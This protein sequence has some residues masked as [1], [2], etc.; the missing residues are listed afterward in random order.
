MPSV[1]ALVVAAGRGERLSSERPKQ[2]LPLGER[3]LLAHSLRRFTEHPGIDH[4]Q[5]VIDPSDSALYEKAVQGFDLLPFV[6]GGE[7]RQGSVRA[8]LEALTHFHPDI[9]LIHDAARPFVSSNLIDR[10][11]DGLAHTAG[12]IPVVPITD[13]LKRLSARQEV[14]SGPD[15]NGLSA[16]QTPQGFR[17]A[18]ILNAHR[19]C[20]NDSLTDDAAVA[21]TAGLPVAAVAGDPYNFKITSRDDMTRA[22]AMILPPMETRTGFGFDVH[23]FAPGHSVTLCGCSIPHN[24]QLSG[25]SD[26]DVGLHA[27]TDALLGALGDGDIGTHFPPGDP[28]WRDAASHQFLEEAHRRVKERGGRLINLDLTLICEAPKI[29]PYRGQM[30]ARLARILDIPEARISIKATTTDKLGFT[31][32]DEGIAAQAIAT[33]TLPV[34]S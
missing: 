1:V 21:E 6:A 34:N 13:T 8:G 14:T 12:C 28:Q 29:G 26:A 7:T 11:L 5:V 17:F 15:R 31:G 25:Y 33:M 16:A 23:R 24:A 22:E 9:V 18:S 20:G 2:Y 30:I 10:V 4:V 27:L 19:T 3:M 32:R